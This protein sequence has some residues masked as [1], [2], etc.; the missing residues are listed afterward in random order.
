M[1]LAP[2]NVS[3]MHRAAHALATCPSIAVVQ[4][5]K[6]LRA[7]PLEQ[8]EVSVQIAQGTAFVVARIVTRLPSTR[9]GER[10]SAVLLVPLGH[11]EA[12][13]CEAGVIC[14]EKTVAT[15]IVSSEEARRLPGSSQFSRGR[16]H[17]ELDSAAEPFD[18]E[19]FV[20]P[21]EALPSEALVEAT[22][23][24]LQ[25]LDYLA[26]A[27][28]SPGGVSALH[29]PLS[30]KSLGG[31]ASKS[32]ANAFTLSVSVHTGRPG[33]VEMLGLE[34][35]DMEEQWR[36]E[37][38]GEL[39]LRRVANSPIPWPDDGLLLQLITH[40]SPLVSPALRGSLISD[41]DTS[42][43]DVIGNFCLRLEAAPDSPTFRR[44]VVFVV[45]R[46]G[47]MQ[48]EP[49]D[50]A[51]HAMFEA[52]SCLTPGSDTF[53]VIAF[54]GEQEVF[55]TTGLVTVSE[56]AIEKCTKWSAA[57]LRAH[58]STEILTPLRMAV[59][60]LTRLRNGETSNF[61]GAD[62]SNASIPSIVLLTDGKVVNEHSI[63]SFARDACH[64]A[65][66]GAPRISCVGVGQSANH[67]F[68]KL[69]SES[70]RGMCMLCLR[71]SNTRN[72]MVRLMASG[73]SPAVLADV[74]VDIEMAHSSNIDKSNV[75]P[76][77]SLECYPSAVPDVTMLGAADVFGVLPPR[78]ILKCAI[79]RGR[80]ADGTIVEA[81]VP[82][83]HPNMKAAPPLALAFAKRRLDSLI[84]K[85]WLA[86]GT[87]QLP[88][89]EMVLGS[90]VSPPLVLISM[91]F[92]TE[93]A[94]PWRGDENAKRELTKVVRRWF[95][96]VFTRMSI[97][98]TA[99]VISRKASNIS[100]PT[101]S[102][103]VGVPVPNPCVPADRDLAAQYSRR[104]NDIAI[105]WGIPCNGEAS[106]LK[107]ETQTA[108]WIQHV[109]N[110]IDPMDWVDA[111]GRK[112]LRNLHGIAVG[113][114]AGLI[115][116]G[117]FAIGFGS[118]QATLSNSSPFGPEASTI[119][120]SIS[121]DGGF[122]DMDGCCDCR[123][124]C[125]NCAPTFCHSCCDFLMS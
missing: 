56:D 13:I 80:R 50:H 18:P 101:A 34:S 61:T 84:G 57:A 97:N 36:N 112:R 24:W 17:G 14:N 122:E 115:A 42:G 96:F 103:V 111:A 64:Y 32:H 12:V 27:Q 109:G 45:D 4:E 76:L 88:R 102:M 77:N 90:Y 67:F 105:A 63:I 82:S 69:L 47:S 10:M 89:S 62:V 29:I 81:R 123:C 44:S 28:A 11:A 125:D 53:N 6:R 79:I 37:A 94:V 48:G 108:H 87:P 20:F 3:S 54:D 1:A 30:L 51:I 91:R 5:D 121:F 118:L 39:S 114:S 98:C 2:P 8:M 78:A 43:A 120:E 119:L 59:G 100:Q 60:L 41:S 15:T 116:V 95:F 35:F 71:R 86:Q 70:C 38:T 65:Q 40:P 26:R 110:T 19:C 117:C 58:G 66:L 74:S 7:L 73:I 55:S 31:A 83:S 49:L 99:L 25:P 85:K 23:R 22:V 113:G 16:G 75:V 107:F 9:F 93:S 52:L 106:L 124:P 21:C 92:L 68:L 104:A 33:A 46:S 72:D